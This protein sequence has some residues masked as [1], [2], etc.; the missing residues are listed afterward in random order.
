[1]LDEKLTIPQK[2]EILNDL[3][4]FTVSDDGSI[5]DSDLF[6]LNDYMDPSIL[7]TMRG[8]ISYKIKLAYDKGER[9]A[10]FKIRSAIGL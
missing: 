2:Q 4:G 8:I 3:F 9:E 5:I 1:M 6:S 7:D 10:R